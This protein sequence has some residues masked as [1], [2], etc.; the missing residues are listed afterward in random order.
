[1]RWQ[2]QI[3]P[4]S[5]CWG[6]FPILYCHPV[7]IQIHRCIWEFNHGISPSGGTT[8][9]SIWNCPMIWNRIRLDNV[10]LS[11]H[12]QY[13]VSLRS[14]PWISVSFWLLMACN[15]GL[16]YSSTNTTTPR[17][18]CHTSLNDSGK[19]SGEGVISSA[20]PVWFPIHEIITWYECS[21]GHRISP[22]S[23]AVR[24]KLSIS[25]SS[26]DNRILRINASIEVGFESRVTGFS[27]HRGR[28]RSRAYPYWQYA[29]L[30]PFIDIEVIIS[31]NILEGLDSDGG[32]FLVMQV[33]TVFVFSNKVG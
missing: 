11:G 3:A 24:D 14:L 28:L 33:F 10:V 13:T 26:Y 29:I 32:S 22:H 2:D 7:W 19:A 1:M 9:F 5:F 30:M 27:K 4:L 25:C 23:S 12:F 21:A 17:P 18:V 20:L 15:S 16:S 6:P 8:C 31:A